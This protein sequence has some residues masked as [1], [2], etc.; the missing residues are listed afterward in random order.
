MSR[1]LTTMKPSS[2]GLLATIGA[3]LW[4][5]PGQTW[6]GHGSALFQW[7]FRCHLSAQSASIRGHDHDVES[8][9]ARAAPPPLEKEP[10]LLEAQPPSGTQPSV[11]SQPYGQQAVSAQPRPWEPGALTASQRSATN[12]ECKGSNWA[13]KQKGQK[14][15]FSLVRRLVQAAVK[16]G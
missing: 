12:A 1:A 6:A 9:L 15:L 5:M 7:I 2:L 4:T 14:Q 13:Q 3:H 11:G 16:S 10:F 8:L